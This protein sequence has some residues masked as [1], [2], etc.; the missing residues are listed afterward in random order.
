MQVIAELVASAS[1][2]H[3]IR[4]KVIDWFST[5]LIDMPLEPQGTY[6]AI[7]IQRRK[8]TDE[9]ALQWLAKMVRP[10]IERLVERRGLD[11][12]LVTLGLPL[13]DEREG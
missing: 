3:Y 2:E 9:K 12:V 7:G 13:I 1:P 4:N 10:T 5:R 11:E 8:T 6:N